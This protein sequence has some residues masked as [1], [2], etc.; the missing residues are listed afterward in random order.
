M[1]HL[2]LGGIR[3]TVLDGGSFRL[4]GAA[5]YGIFPKI[6][7]EKINKPDED[8]RVLLHL[9]PLVV[10]SAEGLILIDPGIG[11]GWGPRAVDRYDLQGQRP[12]SDLLRE[13]ALDPED[14]GAILA[15][16]L[17]FDHISAAAT[18][19]PAPSNEVAG[20]L[21]SSERL[22]SNLEPAL[23]NAK[24]YVQSEEVAY[25]RQPD[26][27]TS[28]YVATS[29]STVYER[30]KRLII[31]RGNSE[32]FPGIEVELTGGHTPGHQVIWV[33]GKEATILVPGDLVPTTSHIRS[34]VLEG[35]DHAPAKSA[36]AKAGLLARAVDS[37]AYVTFYHAPRVRWGRIQSGSAG[38]Y[39]L[40]ETETSGINQEG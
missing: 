5:L 33:K 6:F 34:E 26:L 13:A 11:H 14:V 27:R 36:L 3:V 20:H 10:E 8:N 35:A 30:E 9:A 4:D 21:E 40:E 24:L 28:T 19:K 39:K 29:V 32:P 17:H 37:G 31:L 18:G 15:T 22:A 7:W 38:T 12:L 25:A 1:S 16:H 23:P 2:D